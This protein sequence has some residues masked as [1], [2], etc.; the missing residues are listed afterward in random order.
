MTSQRT[1]GIYGPQPWEPSGVAKYIAESVPHLLRH[2]TPVPAG[3]EADPY[4]FDRVLYH[5]GNNDMHHS[6]FRALRRRPGPVVL[7][8][9]NVLNYYYQA[10]DRLDADE[11]EYVLR[12]LGAS[13]GTTFEDSG[14][15]DRFWR[16]RPDTDRYSLN[17][18]I[19]AQAVQSA[20]CVLVHHPAVAALLQQRF[21][22]HDIRVIPFPVTP[23]AG[24]DPALVRQ[25]FEIPSDAVVFGSFGY[26]G[27][28]KRIESLLTAWCAW[29]GRPTNAVLLLV[30]ALQYGLEIP[31]DRSIR[32]ID[33]PDDTD[34]DQLLLAVDCAVQ[35]RGPWLGESS[36]PV[37]ALLAHNRPAILSDVPAFCTD[38]DHVTHIPGGSAEIDCLVRALADHYYRPSLGIGGF[39]TAYSWSAWAE[40]VAAIVSSAGRA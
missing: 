12:A 1:L 13:L 40:Q 29:P 7:H 34:F 30:G 20:T 16:A 36:G 31:P 25:R 27:E 33:H 17:A 2:F 10:W 32:H 5:L 37:S 23:I 15:L 28:Y 11:H 26:I 9:F 21:T 8:E 3:S 22:G 35:L 6:A 39:D 14:A 24:E 38:S 19:E 18:G 4:T